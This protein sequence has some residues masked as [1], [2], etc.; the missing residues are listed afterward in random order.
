MHGIGSEGTDSR[1]RA[2]YPEGVSHQKFDLIIIGTGSGNSILTPDFDDW[3]VAIVEKDVFG[4]TCLNR[5]CIPT[6]MFVYVADVVESIRHSRRLGI[7]ADL[8]SVRWRDVRDRIFGRIDP[9]EGGGRAYRKSL[10]NVD[11]FEASARFVA[12]GVVEAGGSL[13][14]SDRIVVAAHGQRFG[15]A[16]E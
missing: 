6:K 5:G 13:L 2:T 3:S 11:V 9:I 1:R 12:P 15:G 7:D 10:S 14:T 16:D 8:R 4:G